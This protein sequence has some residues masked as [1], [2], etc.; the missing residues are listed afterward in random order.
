MKDF[1]YG[2][3]YRVLSWEAVIIGV[4]ALTT[5]MLLS[6]CATHMESKVGDATFHLGWGVEVDAGE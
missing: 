4:I 5:I 2:L 3:Y 1:F 6:G